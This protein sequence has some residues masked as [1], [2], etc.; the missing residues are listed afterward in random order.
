MLI[1]HHHL[2]YQ[3]SVRNYFGQDAENILQQFLY[4]LVEAIDMECL[5]PAQ[6]KYSQHQAWTGLIGIVTSHIAFHYWTREK[7]L[8]LDV[9]SCKPFDKDIV[10]SFIHNFWDA[11]N[12]KTLFINR[13]IGKEFEIS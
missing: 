9:Y 12:V 10:I 1:H 6:L 5:I 11:E 2:I 3:S 8:Q 13:E 7:Y 4:G